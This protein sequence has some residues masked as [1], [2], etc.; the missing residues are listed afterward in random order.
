[1]NSLHMRRNER[2]HFASSVALAVLLVLFA[3]AANALAN[4][5]WCV[6]TVN[7]N[8]SCTTATTKAHIQDAV[9]AASEGDVIVVGP[10]YYNETVYV[11]TDNLSI[12]GAQAGRDARWG[13]YNSAEESIVDASGSA[14]GGGEG[15]GFLIYDDVYDVVI[16][17]FTIQGGTTGPYASGI[18]AYYTNPQILDN[19][20][21]NN[22]VGIYM[23]EDYG[24]LV[25]YNLIRNNNQG[26]TGVE[27]SYFA[28]L[29]GFGIAGYY[30]YYEDLITEN[31]FEGNLASAMA[32]YYAYY[33]GFEISHN[34]SKDDGALVVCAY[35][36][37]VSIDHNQGK[38]FGAKGFLPV[39]GTNNADG[40]IDFFYYN[41]Y[42]Q[43]NNNSLDGGRAAAAGYNGIA[44]SNLTWYTPTAETPDYVCDACQVSHNIVVRFGGN[45]IVAEPVESDAT[46][47]Y[48]M[49]SRN[50][51]KDN[52]K[53]GI[54][55]GAA[56]DN[57]YNELFDNKA[58]GNHVFD[59]AD[60]TTGTLTLGT[61]DTWF[62][63]IGALSYPTGLCSA[64]SWQDEY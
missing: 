9:Y 5:V 60:D 56:P 46:L 10:G 37:D 45:G 61:E 64:G 51:V 14:T 55:I 6:P 62:N 36:Y 31:A 2:R 48:T 23:Y 18:Y 40:A 21:Q 50:V 53:D 38:D 8:A 15:A 49:I 1:M 12:F 57:Y 28:G 54:L 7:V 59:C 24:M 52:G 25:E 47:Y 32:F 19:I 35:C 16:D 34:T 11:D 43:I 41:A 63:N 20:I 44:F 27:D 33:Y 42:I 29:K 30:D 17:G 13:R 3:G 39:N 4:T 26:T 22:A 58:M